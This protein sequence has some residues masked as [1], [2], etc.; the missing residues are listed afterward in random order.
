MKNPKNPFFNNLK[1]TSGSLFIFLILKMEKTKTKT[2]ITP[3]RIVR[4]KNAIAR[5]DYI[6]KH[7]CENID[8]MVSVSGC[9]KK[10][11]TKLNILDESFWTTSNG[12][13]KLEERLL[14][15]E[16]ILDLWPKLM[17][18]DIKRLPSQEEKQSSEKDPSYA[19]WQSIGKVNTFLAKKN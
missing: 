7:I 8:I 18:Q 17:E 16:I 11:K 10:L 12:I 6:E 5:F 3:E 1:N 2:T 15:Y 13:K 4:A 14:K 19:V 9:I